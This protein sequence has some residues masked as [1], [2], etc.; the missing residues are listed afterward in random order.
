MNSLGVTPLQEGVCQICQE[1]A[2]TSEYIVSGRGY[3]SLFD[4]MT[5]RWRCCPACNRKR[6]STWVAEKPKETQCGASYIFERA[7]F[8]FLDGLPVNSQEQIFNGAD[9]CQ[10]D[11]QDWI[12]LHLGELSAKK[13]KQYGFDD[14]LF[15]REYEV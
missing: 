14:D 3:G 2:A 11:A 12:D 5:F 7:M 4:G 13:K 1:A 10:I 8:A 9:G 6:F 15:G